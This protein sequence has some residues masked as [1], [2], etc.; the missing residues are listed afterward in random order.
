VPDAGIRG[1]ASPW[2]GEELPRSRVC[3]ITLRVGKVLGRRKVGKHFTLA[4]T[5]TSFRATRDEATIARAAALDGVYVLRTSVHTARLP[6]TEA[7]RS[8]K[9][10]AQIE[11][12]FGSLKT[13]GAKLDENSPSNRRTTFEWRAMKA[14][15]PRC[16]VAIAHAALRRTRTSSSSGGALHRDPMP[17]LAAT[18]SVARSVAVPTP[19]LGPS[20]DL[21]ELLTA[22]AASM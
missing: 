9:R 14:T 7:V 11:R 12:A 19:A 4:I 10:L 6:T 20:P 2:T 21:R 22:R 1:F 5:E 17:L 13:G 16:G 15:L 8:Y 3:P 18:L